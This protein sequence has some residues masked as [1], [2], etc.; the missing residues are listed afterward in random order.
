MASTFEPYYEGLGE[1]LDSFEMEAALVELMLPV[2][3]A[4]EANTPLGPGDKKNGHI[5]DHYQIGSHRHGG[6]KGNR[7]EAWVYND[8]PGAVGFEVGF[9]SKADNPVP[10]HGALARALDEVKG[11]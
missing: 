2:K 5:R 1:V 10:G 7:A 9:M 8:H 11:P 4:A 3:A 6:A